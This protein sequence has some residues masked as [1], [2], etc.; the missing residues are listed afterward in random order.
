[1]QLSTLASRAFVC[2]LTFACCGLCSAGVPREPRKGVSAEQAIEK[3]R[4]LFEREWIYQEP[5]LP[6]RGT[7]S[8]REFEAQLQAMPGDGLG[9]M[10]NATSCASCH[11]KGGG[12]GVERN[13]TL[14][15]L[16]PR[17]AFA[18]N[19]MNVAKRREIRNQVRKE[20]QEL[21]PGL[22]S[23][24]GRLQMETVI[25]EASTRPLYQMFRDK[26][27]SL[28]P[29]GASAT[30]FNANQR[31][32]EV[33]AETPVLAGRLGNFDFYLSQRNSPALYGL[34]SID[35]IARR[36]LE[37]LAE[38]Q[39]KRT[40]GRVSG[41][42]GEGK[43]GW[44]AQTSSLKEFV[45]GACANEL[46]LNVS[47]SPQAPDPLDPKYVSLGKDMDDS[48]LLWLFRFV[49]SLPEPV[50]DFSSTDQIA[51]AR[52][53]KELFSKVGCAIC[54]PA[55]VSPA[56]GIYSD[57][58]L[59]DMGSLLQAASPAPS[60]RLANVSRITLPALMPQTTPPGFRRQIQ[61][62]GGYFGGGSS[63]FFTNKIPAPTPL[64]RP[65]DPT[66]PSLPM[67]DE[68][69][70]QLAAKTGFSWE[71]LQR[72]WR[73]PPLWGVADSAPYL[74]DG[75]AATLDAAILWHGGE[76]SDSVEQYLTLPKEDRQKLIAFLTSLRAPEVGERVKHT[77]AIQ[78]VAEGSADVSLLQKMAEQVNLFE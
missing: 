17:S 8:E 78:P 45:R 36:R 25:H 33:I 39:S 16:D 60:A 12:A 73:T 58:L 14:L 56:E 27:A 68:E 19:R 50:Q 51:A 54:H 62:S 34:D 64:M 71:L 63:G 5:I 57:L 48:E 61:S 6:E 9:P 2:L 40:N 42:V 38:S 55:N 22:I 30:W 52:F 15:T 21:H 43:F 20:I 46:G 18:L 37:I 4:E 44:R 69:A 28:I 74:H 3:G 66:F 35:R 10:H 76:A 77:L 65:E 32:V 53:G 23:P 41:R 24:I 1:M 11:L 47:R 31:T 26:I 59:H 7:Q 13:V 29:G 72:E 67:D 75:R 70:L 49:Q